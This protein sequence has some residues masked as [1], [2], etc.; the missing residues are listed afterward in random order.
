M[1]LRAGQ[2]VES[3]VQAAQLRS[4]PRNPDFILMHLIRI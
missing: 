2:Q 4:R 1:M 3:L